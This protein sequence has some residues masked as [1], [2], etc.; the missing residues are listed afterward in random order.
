VALYPDDLLAIVLPASTYPLQIVQAARYLEAVKDD[1]SLTPDEDWDESVVALLNYPD[2]VEKLSNDLDW[3]WELGQAV[4]DQEPEV[5]AAVEEFRRDAHAA[6]N[7]ASDERQVVEVD[8][9]AVV[10]RHADPEVIYVPYYEPMVVRVRHRYPVY[11]YYPRPCPVYYYPYPAGHYLT[12]SYFWGVTSAFSIGW[13]THHLHLHLHE[14]RSHPYFGHTYAYRHH[15]YWYP[16]HWTATHYRDHP[17]ERHHDG[18]RWRSDRPHRGARPPERSRL[19]AQRP[20][21]GRPP[22]TTGLLAPNTRELDRHRDDDGRGT[23]IHRGGR[24]VT[25]ADT[26][27]APAGYAPAR[28]ATANPASRARSVPDARADAGRSWQ[29]QAS[30]RQRAEALQR[31]RSEAAGRWAEAAQ[32]SR[33][34][35]A[36]GRRSEAAPGRR[37]EI[38]RGSRAEAAPRSRA[39]AAP[40]S[41]AEAAPRSRAEAAPRSRAEAA[42]RVERRMRSEPAASVA[43]AVPQQRPQAQDRSPRSVAEVRGKGAEVRRDGAEARQNRDDGGARGSHIRRGSYNPR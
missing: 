22:A 30:Q 19:E 1:P 16:R 5:I 26:S 38:A 29:A 28:R 39:E 37:T 34:E 10:I 7:L 42:P 11:H 3:T 41:R 36:P 20:S 27:A 21:I 8:E 31:S 32:R 18:N 33:A 17:K 12:S 13:H 43:R 2:V 15:R 23:R 14:H 35:A 4:L 40:R 24:N 6:G 9:E 25:R